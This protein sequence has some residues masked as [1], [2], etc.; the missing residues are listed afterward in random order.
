MGWTG[1]ILDGLKQAE[2]RD[3]LDV[4][5]YGAKGI[6][7]MTPR[8]LLCKTGWTV[9]LPAKEQKQ[10]T[11]NEAK[12]KNKKNPSEYKRK[13]HKSSYDYNFLKYRSSTNKH[14]IFTSP[15]LNYLKWY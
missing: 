6:K 5:D 9:V 11:K 7:E 4:K 14:N 1:E 2:L 15:I 12:N 8:I 3:C 10:K 13:S